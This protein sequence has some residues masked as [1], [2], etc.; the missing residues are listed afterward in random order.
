[1][2]ALNLR[3][4]QPG[5]GGVQ[6]LLLRHHALMR[7][8]SPEES[9]HVLEPDALDKAGAFILGGYLGDQIVGIGALVRFQADAGELKSM[10]T[11]EDARGQG[12]AREILRG[13]LNEARAQDLKHIF[14]ETGSEAPFAPAR[15]LY[16]SEG[17]A[18]CAPFGEYTEDPLS[19]FMTRAL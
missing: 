7:A 2:D 11:H 9:C 14:L 1:M 10:H 4:V 3:Q 19:V 8:T 6:D 5:T 17:F 12:I 18:F 16:A 15:G 13:L